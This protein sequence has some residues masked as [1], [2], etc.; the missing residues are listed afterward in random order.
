MAGYASNQFTK[1]IVRP[2][3]RNFEDGVTEAEL[4][5]PDFETALRQHEAYCRALENC[6]LELIQL[7]C[8]PDFPDSCF[9]EDT[10]IVVD[11]SAVVTRLGHPKRRGEETAVEMALLRFKTIK[12]IQEPGTVDGGDVMRV[13]EHF[14]IGLSQRTNETGAAQ[15]EEVLHGCGKTSSTLAV[16]DYIHLKT[17]IS[18][19]DQETIVGLINKIPHAIAEVTNHQ[20]T[21]SEEEHWAANCLSA[22]GFV[23]V[24]NNRPQALAQL[25]KLGKKVISIETS[26]FQKMD[27]RLTCLSILF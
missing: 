7:P 4:G 18:S 12:R 22:N 11:D 5:K 2:P 15:L 21:V 19:I 25:E 14:F 24:P 13:G 10:A 17:F 26:E 16:K 8:D 9:V 20:V 6:G 3:A 27:G 1:A 23:L